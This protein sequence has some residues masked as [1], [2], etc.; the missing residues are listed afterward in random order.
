MYESILYVNNKYMDILIN[1]VKLT[2]LIMNIIMLLIY[3]YY[4]YKYKIKYGSNMKF[5]LSKYFK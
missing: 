4:L 3:Q 2:S 1:I 5:C